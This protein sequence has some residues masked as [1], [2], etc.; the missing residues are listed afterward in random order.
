M[1]IPCIIFSETYPLVGDTVCLD[2][3]GSDHN[4]EFIKKELS[5]YYAEA[6]DFVERPDSNSRQTRFTGEAINPVTGLPINL[7]EKS[8]LDRV[9]SLLKLRIW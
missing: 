5:H 4:I 7:I 6:G 9:N 2:I 8:L 3:D 1:V